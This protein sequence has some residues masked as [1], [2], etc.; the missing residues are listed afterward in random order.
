MGDGRQFDAQSYH[1]LTAR[2]RLDDSGIK[3]L[4]IKLNSYRVDIGV[5][6]GMFS[7][8]NLAWGIK[9]IDAFPSFEIDE[10]FF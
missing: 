2:T 3:L 9:V 7:I 4:A 10:F 6:Q 5:I 1:E 8:S